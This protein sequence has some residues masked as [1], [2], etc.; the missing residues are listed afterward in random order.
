MQIALC[1][2]DTDVHACFPVMSQLRPHLEP[3]AFLTQVKRQFADGYRIAAVTD[4]G[5]V[6]AVAGFRVSVCLAWGR[7][8]YVDDL[9][10]DGEQRSKGYGTRLLDWLLEF[11]RQHDCGQLHLD[12]GVQRIDA[13]RFYERQGMTFSSHHY[14]VEV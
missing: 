11:A 12:S 14:C 1:E 7:H 6:V 10:T 4:A 2:T 3:E 9:V 5:R 8:V 13:H